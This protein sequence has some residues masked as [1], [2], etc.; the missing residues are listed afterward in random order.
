MFSNKFKKELKICLKLAFPIIIAQ[1]GVVL[2]GVTDNIM[3]GRFLGKIPL[4]AS[5]VA[6]S[7]AFLIASFAVG[8]FSVIAPMVSKSLAEKN[9]EGIKILYTSTLWVS[10]IFTIVLSLIGY[11]A[12][13]NFE[14]FQQPASINAIVLPFFIIILISNIPLYFFLGLKQFADGLSKP[15]V[16]MFITIIGLIANIFGNYYL[17]NGFW[18]IKPMGLIGA[19]YATLLTRILM[20]IGMYCYLKYGESFNKYIILKTKNYDKLIVKEI[21]ERSIPGGSQL[22]FEIAAFS[23]AV[24]MMGWIS[25]TVLAAHQ[26]AINIAS[27][28][29]MMATGLS[30][31]GSIRVGDAWGHRN[32]NRI[33]TAGNVAYF[34]VFV[35]MCFSMAL[36][37]IFKLP[38]LSMF[39]N[40][41]EVIEKALPLLTI[42]AFFQLSDG[43][44]VVGLGALRGLADIKIPTAITFVSYWLLA[45]PLGYIL[46]FKFEY[47][48]VGI[49]IG[50]LIGLSLSAILLYSRF[51][52][53]V[54]LKSLRKRFG[55]LAT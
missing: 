44:Q 28:T 12:Y 2:M 33:R 24:I 41:N 26:I 46:A 14:L 7:I 31:A 5:G 48:S 29:Y 19:G 30:F 38:L 43:I 37:L 45:L 10:L 9:E 15:N 47:G 55:R 27:T 22:F 16:V 32:P 49:W 3:V 11:L 54:T 51:R 4:G 42:A 18:R 53:L 40:D 6:N 23:L 35:F 36:I 34:S 1:L 13:V 39:I 52:N 21:L 25:E 20:F 17:I 8:G 50:L